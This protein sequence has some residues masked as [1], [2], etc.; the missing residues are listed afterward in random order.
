MDIKL[1]NVLISKDG[2]LKLCDFGFCCYTNNLVSKKLGTESYMAP[3]IH[4]ARINPCKAQTAD[5]FS[6]GVLFFILAFGAPPFNTAEKQDTYFR[7]IKLRPGS[8][9]FF[10]FHPHTR[11][12]FREGKIEDSFMSL[13]LALLCAD[14]NQRVQSIESLL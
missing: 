9:D 2:I 8:T 3:E 5:F 12:L 10:K 1:E 7:Y 11:V 6:L 4:E 13:L 14:P